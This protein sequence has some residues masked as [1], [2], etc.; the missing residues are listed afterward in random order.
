MCIVI[1]FILMGGGESK[2]SEM[3][4]FVEREWEVLR[5]EGGMRLLRNVDSDREAE[6]VP[7]ML[8]PRRN[9]EKEC[10]IYNYRRTQENALVGVYAV[11]NSKSG[12]GSLC[13]STQVIRVA[14]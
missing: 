7:L 10:D 4:R 8:D 2:S 14:L 6:L 9:F 5:E 3:L 13:G 1:D 12:E 11:Q